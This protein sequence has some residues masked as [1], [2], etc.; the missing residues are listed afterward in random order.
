MLFP[1]WT[2]APVCTAVGIILFGGL[3]STSFAASYTYD[4]SNRLVRIS[5]TDGREVSYTY[6]AA[7]NLTGVATRANTPPTILVSTPLSGTVG[8]PVSDYQ[9]QTNRSAEVVGFRI[10]G[11]PKG[12]VANLGNAVN[13]EGKA[14]GV[15]YGTPQVPGTFL[16]K[17][18]AIG[19]SGI[20]QEVILPVQIGNSFTD[21]KGGF[22]LAGR[23]SGRIDPSAISGAENGGWLTLTL[24][25][26]GAFTGSLQLGKSKYALRGV[27]DGRT[28]V[29]LTLNITRP[30]LP[31]LILDLN[32]T[33]NGNNRGQ[34][35]GTLRDGGTTQSL[36]LEREVW[37]K[38]FT[39]VLFGAKAP[40]P[41]H[42][43]LEL[44]AG[45]RGDADYPQGWGFMVLSVN[46][47]GAAKISGQLADGTKITSSS[48]VSREGEVSFFVGLYGGA[49]ALVGAVQI[50]PETELSPLDNSIDGQAT[51]LRPVSNKPTDTLYPGG[52]KTTMSLGGAVYAAPLAG[53]RVLHLGNKTPHA[54]VQLEL[55]EGSL[56]P[57]L[58]TA[59]TISAANKVTEFTP[60]DATYKLTF[61]PA[62]GLFSGSF[63]PAAGR[64]PI[65]FSGLLVPVTPLGRESGFGYFLNPGATKTSPILSGGAWIGE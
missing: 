52:F 55:S 63:V 37:N 59:L 19:A 5:H 60:N 40:V 9:I 28:G 42:L 34:I 65:P 31:D 21:T 23:F 20:G 25:P 50:N 45:H 62:K 38:S 64:K 46:S 6:D 61:N 51:W 7:G 2:A 39:P 1:A 48:I 35:V 57:S 15:I 47:L 24:S 36:T 14:P 30:G 54:A 56:S 49:G 27:F 18:A 32:L 4:L 41:Y 58:T 17:V 12:L 22:A 11:L 3:L 10:T 26:N 13:T 33:L 43:A 8:S 29:G 44:D 53:Y 16:V